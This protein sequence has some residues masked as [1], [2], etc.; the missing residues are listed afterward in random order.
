MT[1]I[2]K[3]KLQRRP[4]ISNSAISGKEFV[5]DVAPCAE[6]ELYQD[7]KDE[8]GWAGNVET[9]TL[10]IKENCFVRRND[11]APHAKGKY[12]STQEIVMFEQRMSAGSDRLKR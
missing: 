7:E 2:K 12:F 10:R 6:G 8:I 1:A 11:F 3:F 5:N 4:A 9:L